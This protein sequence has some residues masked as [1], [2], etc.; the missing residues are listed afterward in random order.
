MIKVASI[1]AFEGSLSKTGLSPHHHTLGA[2]DIVGF[3]DIVQETC[4]E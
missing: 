3:D 4:C 1:V 2:E